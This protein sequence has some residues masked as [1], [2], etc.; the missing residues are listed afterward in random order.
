MKLRQMWFLDVDHITLACFF[1]LNAKYCKM[2]WCLSKFVLMN[3]CECGFLK[4]CVNHITS[5]LFL[6]FCP[7][8]FITKFLELFFFFFLIFNLHIS[9]SHQFNLICNK[10]IMHIVTNFYKPKG[11]EVG[12]IVAVKGV[13]TCRLP[14]KN[15]FLLYV[16]IYACICMHISMFLCYMVPTKN[17]KD[18]SIR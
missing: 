17:V 12:A 6:L 1:H 2:M 8:L 11:L 14:L 18:Q 9:T 3:L 13:C 7:Y 4:K 15:I 5:V 16:Y 10:S